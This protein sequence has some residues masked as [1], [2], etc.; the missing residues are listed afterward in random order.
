MIE[1]LSASRRRCSGTGMINEYDEM[2]NRDSRNPPS[3]FQGLPLVIFPL[4]LKRV[5]SIQ[6]N[7]LIA[8]TARAAEK[9]GLARRHAPQK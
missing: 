5:D 7:G 2:L 8:A 3:F 1:S 4:Y 9:E 6:Q